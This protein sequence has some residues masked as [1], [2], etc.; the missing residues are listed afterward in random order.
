MG[1]KYANGKLQHLDDGDDDLDA[2]VYTFG[3]ALDFT[4]DR[5]GVKIN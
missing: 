5:I 1:Q 4:S 2:L 3:A